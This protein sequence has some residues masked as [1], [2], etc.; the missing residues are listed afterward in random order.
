MIQDVI[1][2]LSLIILFCYISYLSF[3]SI[4]CQGR[5]LLVSSS[6]TKLYLQHDATL[7]TTL[8]IGTIPYHE[9]VLFLLL[10][11][12]SIWP[13]ICKNSNDH[14]LWKQ[15]YHTHIFL[16][17]ILYIM[18]WVC[19]FCTLHHTGGNQKCNPTLD[20]I[21]P[22]IDYWVRVCYAQLCIAWI[23][24]KPSLWIPMPPVSPSDI[25]FTT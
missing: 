2:T 1:Q 15:P 4:L 17:S 25:R 13:H 19:L 3:Y 6:T 5:T 7:L 24:E 20:T 10:H 9:I 12:P 14:L 23:P 18:D 22:C 16:I 11:N 8:F 21:Y